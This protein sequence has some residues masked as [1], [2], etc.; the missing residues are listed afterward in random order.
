MTL[1]DRHRYKQLIDLGHHKAAVDL[2]L[3]RHKKQDIYAFYRSIGFYINQ[4]TEDYI[5]LNAKD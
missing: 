4:E 3:L 5:Q 2:M 1:A